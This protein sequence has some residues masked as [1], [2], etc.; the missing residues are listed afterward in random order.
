MGGAL[1]PLLFSLL[2]SSQSERDAAIATGMEDG[3]SLSYD[4]LAEV[5]VDLP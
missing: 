1:P 2:Y 3:T 5:V 4:R